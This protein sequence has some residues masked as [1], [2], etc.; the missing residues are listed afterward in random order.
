MK[1]ITPYLFEIEEKDNL[2]IDEAFVRCKILNENKENFKKG[3]YGEIA[4]SLKYNLEWNPQPNQIA[5]LTNGHERF[6][7]VVTKESFNA[8][9]HFLK[10]TE[11][12]FTHYI[13]CSLDETQK[14]IRI[15]VEIQKNIA[16]LNSEQRL[17]N[18][19]KNLD[20]NFKRK[21]TLKRK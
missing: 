13:F 20:N 11:Q 12:N 7:V 17:M 16:E 19:S 18:F 6:Q 21:R 15:E 3:W 9:S 5:D 4:V 8:Y 10:D 1:Q 14:Y 2:L